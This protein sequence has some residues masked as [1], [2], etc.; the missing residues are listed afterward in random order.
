[1][2]VVGM[3]DGLMRFYRQDGSQPFPERR[4]VPRHNGAS[5][6]GGRGMGGDVGAATGLGTGHHGSITGGS[7][8]GSGSGLKGARQVT[9]S[10]SFGVG[11]ALS[12]GGRAE[13]TD[14]SSARDGSDGTRLGQYAWTDPLS[15]CMFQG[16]F[17]L[18]GG[19]DRWE[20]RK[21]EDVAMRHV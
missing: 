19:S 9:S 5:E 15:L 3:L 8:S 20:A 18:M 11:K 10:R 6:S 14:V 17:L 16:G 12:F 7:G 2:L 4:L 1:M 13:I 21:L